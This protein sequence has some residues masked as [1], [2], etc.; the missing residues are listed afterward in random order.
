MNPLDALLRPTAT[1]LNAAIAELTPA[2]E[3]CRELDGIVA[4]V[5]LRHTALAVTFRIDAG[6]VAIGSGAAEQPDIA[7]TGS[8]SALARMAVSGD[9]DAI[10]DGRV[11]LIG[12][13]ETA[14][15]FQRLLAYARPDPE[16][17]LSRVVGDTA[18][19][20]AGQFARRLGDWAK[21]ARSTMTANLR[22]YLQEE[23]RDVPSRW[24]AERFARDVDTLRDDVERLAARIDRLGDR[25]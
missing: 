22:E 23:G 21:D 14:A 16:E 25:H 8:L 1:L 7:I 3:L 12:D 11:E 13:A 15:A 5:R 2:R 18:A 10:R 17:Q 19:H 4:S 24:E 9:P 20:S 6:Q